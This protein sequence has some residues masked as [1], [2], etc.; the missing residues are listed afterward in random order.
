MALN[1]GLLIFSF[2]TTSILIVPFINLLYKLKFTRRREAPKKGK[3]PFFDKVHDKKAGTP[4]GG[5]ILIIAFVSLAFAIIF[6]LV[7]YLGVPVSAAY[8]VGGEINIILLTM[9]MWVGL[10]RKHKFAIQWGLAFLIGFLIYQNL[11]ISIIN[12]PVFDTVVNLGPWYIPFAAFVIVSFVNAVNITD[13]LDGLVAGLLLICLFSFWIISNKVFDTPLSVFISL[14]L[15]ALV[16]FLYFNIWPARIFLGDTGA[17]SFGATLA[18][19]G[20]LSGKILALVA[21]GG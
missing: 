16:A 11:G 10:R 15:G 8:D 4:I 13:G 14:W 5:G 19:I 2:I 3:I 7:S 12:I 6:P 17:L 9:G 21:I 1:L 20:L 18:V